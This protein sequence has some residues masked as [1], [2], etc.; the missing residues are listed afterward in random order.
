MMRGT[1]KRKGDIAAII[2]GLAMSS[3]RQG[4]AFEEMAERGQRPDPVGDD[5]GDGD[6]RAERTRHVEAA[7]PAYDR[8]QQQLEHERRRS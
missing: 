5:L 2:E 4:S 3:K 8:L 6:H 7:E 1:R